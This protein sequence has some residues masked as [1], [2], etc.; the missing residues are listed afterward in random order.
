MPFLVV[1]KVNYYSPTA[2]VPLSVAV[3]V[4]GSSHNMTLLLGDSARGQYS[5]TI[6]ALDLREGCKQYYFTVQNQDGTFRL[7]E[8]GYYATWFDG[9]VALVNGQ[10]S[11][12]SP[13]LLCF[14][15][16]VP[17]PEPATSHPPPPPPS[18]L[19]DCGG[20]AY[21]IELGPNTGPYGAVTL[22][23][24]G[25]GA[26]AIKASGGDP[27]KKQIFMPRISPKLLFDE[28]NFGKGTF[29]P[30]V[31]LQGA[32]AGNIVRGKFCSSFDMTKL[33]L[34]S[35]AGSILTSTD[36]GVNWDS[37][38]NPDLDGSNGCA[39]SYDGSKLVLVGMYVLVPY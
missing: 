22:N 27:L 2:L 36:S 21:W 8:T 1:I 37:L 20:R 14:D 10:S 35:D 13:L 28:T 32:Y 34:V 11:D 19:A 18:S 38:V 5:V 30:S 39:S 31:S 3:T 4:N 26:A 12:I 24:D 25:F 7:P 16:W 23:N 17:E 6:P 9:I 15:N 33:M 29:V